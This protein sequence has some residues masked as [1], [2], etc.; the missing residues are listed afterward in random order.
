MRSFYLFIL[1]FV[2][3]F[4]L[5]LQAQQRDDIRNFI[6]G[7]SL[8]NHLSGTDETTVP[9]WLH[10]LATH[11]GQ[12]YAVDG[13]WGFL[14]SFA[15]DLPPIANWSFQGV[16]GVWQSERQDFGQADFNTVMI[17]PANFIQYQAPDAAFDGDNDG[18]ASPVS[19]TLKVLNWVD[20]Q[21]ADI[22]YYIYEGWAEMAGIASSFP[23][24]KKE[25][26]RYH[27][28]VMGDAHNWYE[29]YVDAL[30]TA[31]PELEI[32]LIPVASILSEL[33]TETE[34][35][36]I[37]ASELYSDDAPHGTPS[38]YFLASLITY[39]YQYGQAAPLGFNIP[40]TVHPLVRNNYPMIVRF[41]A[42]FETA[43]LAP[44]SP[45]L[46]MGLDGI[47]DWSAQNPFINIMKSAR[48][49]TGHLPGQWGGWDADDLERGGYLD[50]DGWLM[51]IP[52]ELTHVESFVLSN[53]PPEAGSLTGQYR[54][55]Y[56]GEGDITLSGRAQNVRRSGNTIWFDFT[57]GEDLVGIIIKAT[58]PNGTG[59][60]IRDITVVKKSNI[61]LFEAGVLFN[62]HWIPR[63]KDLRSVRFM[64]WMFTNGS[65][66]S[67]WDERAKPRDYT[68]VRRGAPVE[69]MVQL[70]NEI[71]AD[72]WF[73][74]PHLADAEYM[75]NFAIYVRDHLDE[76]LKT[77]VEYSNEMWNFT[78][79]QTAWA[80]AQAE[81]RWGKGAGDGWMQFAG[82]RAAIMAQIWGD[83]YGAEA[84]KR[85]VRV[86]ATHTAWPGLE[87]A[88]LQAPLWQKETGGF[89]PVS[90]FD[91]YAVTGYFGLDLGTDEKAPMVLDWVKQSMA[92]A[93]QAATAQEL[94]GS[95]F[96]DY[97]TQHQ[98][99]LA[100]GLAKDDILAGSLKHLLNEA[101]PYQ[102]KVAT[103]NGLALV[104]YE[105]GS[106]VVGIGEW[107]GNERLNGFFMH[108]NYTQEMA[109]IYK[110]LLQGW[111]DAGG[112][113]FN[114]F[115]DV[116]RISRWG[117][118]GALRHLDDSNPR[119]DVLADFNANTPAWWSDRPA[120]DFR[121]S[122]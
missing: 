69:V 74:M 108:L 34:L 50:V 82:M 88:L 109:D 48:P 96:N 19:A 8:I 35:S 121:G 75:R 84:D 90:V 116:A 51:H 111:R 94:S 95:A 36:D 101:W 45:S 100:A 29:A 4:T 24:S 44:N 15:A 16:P 119:W 67:S 118:W 107:A 105:G 22:K 63:I 56:T 114:A 49:W 66:Q 12:K 77:Y 97:I 30:R 73:N 39:Q 113:L 98:Y 81:A 85:L 32:Q 43:V 91:A 18:G 5:P 31:R 14:R 40:E 28:Y 86:I 21:Q 11:A 1:A 78:F 64:D 104:M 59:N 53:Q 23:P 20:G 9:F 120:S 70:A 38:L 92:A 47:A 52:D 55:Q 57:P 102:Y 106:H 42:S 13:Q 27:S 112:T 54:V 72:P 26:S 62:P 6:F 122:N 46:A 68:Y 83:A 37:S 89:A 103:E 2:L 25:F 115:V 41:I 76:R 3:L 71:G 87:E 117:S 93:K 33:L 10:R 99:D 60:Y 17:N 80:L 79:P 58:D 7:N 61:A 65:K 110:V